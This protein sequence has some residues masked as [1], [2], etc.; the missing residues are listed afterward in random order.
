[1]RIALL[2]NITATLL[3]LV[4]AV[5]FNLGDKELGTFLL[6]LAI[7]NRIGGMEA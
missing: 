7:F 2:C 1:M 5:V 4:A 6:G 3:L